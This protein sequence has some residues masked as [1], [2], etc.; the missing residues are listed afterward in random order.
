MPEA[1]MI[2][3]RLL[4]LIPTSLFHNDILTLLIGGAAAFVLALAF[5]FMV[6]AFCYRVGWLDR[7]TARRVHKKRRCRV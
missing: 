2:Y 7:P 3:I 6:K 1:S 5:T 4:L